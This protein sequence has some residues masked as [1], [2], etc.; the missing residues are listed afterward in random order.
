[1]SLK[2]KGFVG[3]LPSSILDLLLDIFLKVVSSEISNSTG[4][5]SKVCHAIQIGRK[6]WRLLE[7]VILHLVE[8]YEKLSAKTEIFS[9]AVALWD[10]DFYVK[11]DDD[12]HVNIGTLARTLVN[13]HNKPWL[14]IGFMKYGCMKYDE[15]F[16]EKALEIGEEGNN[17]LC[18]ASGHIYAISKELALYIW[19]NQDILHRYAN[20]DVSLGTWL[21]GLNV[22]HVDGSLCCGTPTGSA[23][24]FATL[25]ERIKESMR[26][27]EM[28][29]ACSSKLMGKVL[30][31]SNHTD[32]LVLDL[33]LIFTSSVAVILFC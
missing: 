30:T 25:A 27:V 13:H 31:L 4:E 32:E 16:F 21:I 15:V 33:Y 29:R 19:K 17:Y 1:M 14:Y 2:S 5:D 9:T 20:E 26:H 18:H 6:A 24:E 3:D 12:V 28:T 8:A 7:I 11:I 10:V 23:A 22:E